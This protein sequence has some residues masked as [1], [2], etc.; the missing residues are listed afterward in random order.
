VDPEYHHRDLA[1]GPQPGH[2]CVSSNS[3]LLFSILATLSLIS[4]VVNLG[5]AMRERRAL[6]RVLREIPVSDSIRTLDELVSLRRFLAESIRFDRDRIHESRP[7]LRH[8]AAQI[9]AS[10]HGFC[11]ENAR[12]ASLLLNAAAVRA[13]RLYLIGPRWGHVLVEHRWGD[14]W[15]LFDAHADPGTM[16]PDDSLGRIPS[17]AIDRLPNRYDRNPWTDYYRI[18]ALYRIPPLRPLSKLRPPRIVSVISES[19]ALLRACASLAVL[20]VA[21]ALA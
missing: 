14:G 17:T 1:T 13:N 6:R 18:Q 11:G 2:L 9:L 21:V 15:V 3:D 10:G 8:S 4:L 19:P 7:F 5:L 12:V 20:L 16:P